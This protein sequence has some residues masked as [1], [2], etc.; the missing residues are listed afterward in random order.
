MPLVKWAEISFYLQQIAIPYSLVVEVEKSS[1]MDFSESI[2]VK[3]YDNAEHYSVDSYFFAYFHDI[4]GALEQI[5]DAIRTHHAQPAMSTPQSVVDTTVY[6]HSVMGLDR[7]TSLPPEHSSKASSGFRFPSFLRPL[8]ETLSRPTQHEILS[9]SEDFTH[10]TRRVDSSSFVPVTVSSPA[11]PPEHDSRKSLPPNILMTSDNHTYP[12]STSTSHTDP[13]HTSLS[14]ESSSWA[15][16]VPSWLKGTRRVFG[17]PTA[18]HEHDTMSSTA[19]VKET[20]SSPTISSS[21]PNNRSNTGDLAFSILETPDISADTE[22]TEK[23]RAAFAYDERETLL[24]CML[25][26]IFFPVASMIFYF[27]DFPGYI[28]RLLPIYGRLYVSTNFFC[29]K[30]SGPLTVRTRVRAFT[31]TS[32]R[33]PLINFVR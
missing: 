19:G 8:Q 14:R 31:A 24:G 15:I 27:Q 5:R 21:L 26:H 23:F 22:A 1:A 16:G 20:Y 17:S 6:R 30:S 4:P 28:F 32:Y 2:E 3:V 7:A 25:F 9:E 29:F 12:P 10:I 33:Y 11:V 18:L 13:D